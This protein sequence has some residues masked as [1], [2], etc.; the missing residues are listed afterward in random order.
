MRPFLPP[1]THELIPRILAR[2]ARRAR[3]VRADLEALAVSAEQR[4]ACRA[5]A[6]TLRARRGASRREFLLRPEVRAWL[7][8]A[9]E[10]LALVRPGTDDLAL[11]DRVSRGPHLVALLP[12]GRIDAAFRRRAATLGRSLLSRAY[13]VLPPLLAFLTPPGR[14]FGSFAP[15]LEADGEEARAGGEVHLCFPAPGVLRL[16]PG[17]RMDLIG[18]AAIRRRGPAPAGRSRMGA[19][20]GVI[21]IT[22]GG[23]VRGWFPREV[24]EGSDIVLARRVV[25]TRRGLR[26]G[27]HVAGLSARLGGA[28][29]LVRE[30]WEEAYDE[31]IAHT[32]VVVP[33][34]ER[35]TVSF[36]LSDRPGTSYINVWGKSLVD[37]ADDLVH[38]T[39]HH[40]LHGLEEIEGP[41]DLDDGEPR[42]ESPWRRSVRPIHGILHA[43]YTFTYRA[44]LFRRMLAMPRRAPSHGSGAPSP[45]HLPHARLR[46][47]LS[48][49]ISALRR[50]LSDLRDAERLGLLTAAGIRLRRAI[51]SRVSRMAPR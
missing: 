27:S 4:E 50:S 28:L 2:N 25:S 11:F 48:W 39:A 7:C 1:D 41:L 18:G 45:G 34:A 36:S 31:V 17:A 12:R 30:A 44:E 40:R 24:I 6:A 10:A 42:Y 16:R 21:R 46:R 32:R 37:L 19:P 29:A 47:E 38:E 3:R 22:R 9:E 51:V 5:L 49:E 15:D 8:A 14:R 26:T 33:L 13:R 43:A 23:A 35:G 20:A